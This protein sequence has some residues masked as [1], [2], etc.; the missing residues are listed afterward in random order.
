MDRNSNGYTFMFAAI[1]VAVVGAL[2][3]L[4]ATSLK[5]L[6]DENVKKEKMQ[7]ILAS[8]GVVVE[9]EQAPNQFTSVIKEQ[10]ALKVDGSVDESTQ[11]FSIDLKNELSKKVEDQRFP[12]Y[13]AEQDGKKFYIV[14]LRGAGLWDAIWGYVALEED[15]NTIKGTVFD[16]KG[17]TP[18]L[19]AEITQKWFQDRFIGEKIMDQSGEIVGVAVTK[20]NTSQSKDDNKVDAISGSTITGNGV[21][22]MIKERLLN[23]KNYFAN[24]KKLALNN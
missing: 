9:R 5:D 24:Q 23:Y 18:G 20:G 4:A 19:G 21:T 8:V 6:Q 15:L 12:L 17:E 14:P 1:M 3:A 13:V 22:D 11:A 10:L 16:H 2:L 7:N